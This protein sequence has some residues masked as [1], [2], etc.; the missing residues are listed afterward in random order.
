MV[1][2]TFSG[3]LGALFASGMGWL[4]LPSGDWRYFIAAC[5]APAVLV[6]IYSPFLVEESPRY[7]FLSDREGDGL[8][9]LW[10]IAEQNNLEIPQGLYMGLRISPRCFG[11]MQ[12]L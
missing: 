6:G 12:S 8:A 4:F 1:A 9:V 3:A 7:L 5:A 10:R 11:L 2:V